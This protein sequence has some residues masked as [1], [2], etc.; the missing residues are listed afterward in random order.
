MCSAGRRSA[1]RGFLRGAVQVEAGAVQAEA[2]WYRVRRRMPDSGPM[3]TATMACALEAHGALTDGCFLQ[4]C[5]PAC[6]PGPVR[7]VCIQFPDPHFKRRNH[8]RRIF[9]PNLVKDVASL[10]EPGGASAAAQLS[11]MYAT[12]L[13]CPLPSLSHPVPIIHTHACARA[14]THTYI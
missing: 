14:H 5:P 1:G 2:H 9:Q 12:C 11:A 7:L 8:K 4:L 10:L 6:R 3:G 13:P